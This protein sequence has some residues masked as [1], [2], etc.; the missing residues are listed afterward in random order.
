MS[1][2]SESEIHKV[3]QLTRIELS[4]DE[5]A[6]MTLEVGEILSFVET[7][8]ATDV[9]GVVPTSQVTGL[10][11]VWREDEVIKSEISPKD[12][13][14]GAPALQDNYVKVKKVL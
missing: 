14:S 6:S 9:A 7:I 11:D 4:A 13:L 8:Q 5:L 12:L 3:A 1:Q 10:N 2:M